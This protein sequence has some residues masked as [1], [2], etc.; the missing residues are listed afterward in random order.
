[1]TRLTRAEAHAAIRGWYETA[2]RDV[3]PVVA[4]SRALRL[5]NETLLV[6]ET[7]IPVKPGAQLVGIAIGKAAADMAS[8]LESGM[9]ARLDR[10]LLLTKDGHLDKAPES[11]ST[12]EA[13]HPIPDQR[14][15][16]A[17]RAILEAVSDLTEDDVVIVLVSGGGS[18]L[19][20]AP[21]TPLNLGDIQTVTG[22][23]LRAG[24][25]IQHLNAVR[26]ELS[27]VKGGGLR[28]TIGDARCVSIILSDVLGNDPTVIAS[29]PTIARQPD[30]SQALHLLEK[31]GVTD[32]VPDAVIALLRSSGNV[33]LRSVEAK[34]D[35]FV[36][37]GD[38]LAF[39]QGVAAA[40]R[41]DGCTVEVAME[42]AEGEASD[43][44]S[45]FIAAANAHDV[46]VVLGGGEATVT[47]RGD[48]IGGRNTEFAL[49]AAI[50]L[51]REN[52]PLVVA[53]LASDG[54]DGRID[55]AGAIA[56]GT[57]VSR[58]SELGLDP[59]AFLSEN[60]SGSFF[61]RL[62]DLIAPGPTGT[63]VNDVYIAVRVKAGDPQIH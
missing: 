59:S 25:P 26:S 42:L 40:A 55:A 7:S 1:M 44:A 34:G 27:E 11:W 54:Q 52:S 19:L 56:D 22:L 9:G 18:A 33:T 35:A 32:E 46:D 47:V 48:G 15:V 20:E 50:E 24:A 21:R 51:D 28:R 63:N 53:S 4:V 45:T 3:D 60:D 49:A 41:E 8:A 30:P 61:E 29:G 10:R 16:D 31:Y 58:S 37:V 5:E 6:G 57:T 36:V 39:V 62:G 23:L 17:T 13:S 2:L 38:N 12:F 43:L 14:G